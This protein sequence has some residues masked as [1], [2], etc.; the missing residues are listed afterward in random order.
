[1]N[2]RNKSYESTNRRSREVE[3]NW[4]KSG[5]LRGRVNLGKDEPLTRAD[6][7]SRVWGMKQ[8]GGTN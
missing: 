3:R 7:E 2:G 8:C 6:S 5:L 1:V 4:I